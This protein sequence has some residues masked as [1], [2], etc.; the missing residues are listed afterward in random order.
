LRD[1]GG[2]F[3]TVKLRHAVVPRDGKA[4]YSTKLSGSLWEEG[5]SDY[6][7]TFGTPPLPF[8]GIASDADAFG[9]PSS[10]LGNSDLKVAGTNFI[11]QTIP[12][13]PIV[14]GS[15]S[16]AELFREG[17]PSMIGSTLLKDRASF[18]R[19]LG[20][21]YLNLE[22]GWKPLISDLKSA[23]KAISD[24]YEILK[25]LEK[26]SG[27]DL[28]RQ[29]ILP[30]ERH[31]IVTRNNSQYPG[32]MNN[33]AWT[34]PP[35]YSTSDTTTR[36]QWFSG[37]YKYYYEPSRMTE[38]GRINTQAR[39]L[40]GLEITPEVLWNL[41]PWS[42]LVDWFANVGPLLSN[43]SSFQQDG[44]V[45]K[46]GYVMETT[47]REYRRTVSVSGPKAGTICQSPVTDA[48]SGIR[49]RREQASPYGFGLNSS[50]FT[51][52]QWAILGA[53]GIT[54]IPKS[55]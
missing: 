28:R 45:M 37:C 27:K 10:N 8:R 41:A 29:R 14:D 48:F 6:V 15:V 32:W 25:Q 54:R 44:L 9:W 46:Y 42:W 17:L 34:S 31:L 22:F 38:L 24:S 23:S 51:N 7:T 5:S 30:P 13:N 16:L 20:S 55:L 21:E 50:A 12:T 3:D 1:I 53:L 49:K 43:V 2:P 33:V 52:R 26:Y 19:N 47:T 39:L 11:S 35:E 36:Q 4:E 18:F 40:Y